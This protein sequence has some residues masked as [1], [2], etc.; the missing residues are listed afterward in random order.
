MR[1]KQVYQDER[2]IHR[3]PMPNSGSNPSKSLLSSGRDSK[4][5]VDS[6]ARNQKLIVMT[7]DP[8]SMRNLVANQ[9]GSISNMSNP[10]NNFSIQDDRMK[11]IKIKSIVFDSKG[12]H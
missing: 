9:D 12:G 7:N 3:I 8:L 11:P 10:L 2:M 6:G 4:D 1:L 5:Q